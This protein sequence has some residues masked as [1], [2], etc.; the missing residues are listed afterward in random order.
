MKTTINILL[1]SLLT[2]L[3]LACEEKKKVT[4]K[5]YR[6]VQYVEVKSKPGEIKQTF[7]GVVEA[8]LDAQLS[9]RVNGTIEK[10]HVKLGDKVSK[11]QL[12][13]SLDDTDYQVSVQLAQA[14]LQQALANQRN[15]QA[16]YERTIG[17]YEN[18]N[19]AKSDLDAARAAAESAKA[20]SEVAR[21]QLE[22]AQLQLAYTKLQAPQSCS[23]AQVLADT[24]ENVS[25]GQSV[26]RI[27]CGQCSKVRVAIP[28]QYIQM[29]QT[30]KQVS[31]SSTAN[32]DNTYQA[33]I[34][35]VGVAAATG[36]TFPV[37]AILQGNCNELKSGMTANV[38]FDFSELFNELQ[39]KPLFVPYLS[40]GEDKNG[41]YLFVLKAIGDGIYKA[42]KTK[43]VI[44]EKAQNGVQIITGIKEGD[45]IATAGVRRLINGMEVKLLDKPILGNF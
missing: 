18:N 9:F 35:E 17:L 45:L 34:S 15:N 6:P 31:V 36:G 26:I 41:R 40:V 1:I 7:S 42:E 39:E 37:E 22:S 16:V 43:V 28:E 4:E 27:N 13:V 12:L 2:T 5:V 3:L 32:P 33:V 30:N 11:G 38:K 23:I 44:G 24:N 29:I 8:G 25:A 10:R 20:T 19:A 21:K 14:N